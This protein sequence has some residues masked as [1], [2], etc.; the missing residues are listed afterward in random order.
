MLLTFDRRQAMRNKR[1]C[2][3]ALSGWAL[4]GYRYD[5][6]QAATTTAAQITS[7]RPAQ[8]LRG[9]PASVSRES[10]T[11]ESGYL[12]PQSITGSRPAIHRGESR[13]QMR[14]DGSAGRQR[15]SMVVGMTIDDPWWEPLLEYDGLLL[16]GKALAHMDPDKILIAV[17]SGRLRR[18]QRA[19]YLPSDRP[20]TPLVRARAAVLSSG[21]PRAVA[22]HGTAAKVHG[23]E[24][25]QPGSAEDVLVDNAVRRN[26]RKLLRFHRRALGPGEAEVIGGVPVT[27]I[28]RTLADL[29]ADEE[30]LLAVYALDSAIRGGLCTTDDVSVVLTNWRPAKSAIRVR[31]RLQESDGLAESPLETAG[32][33]ALRDAGLPLPTAQFQVWEQDGTL[34]ARL[35]AAYPEQKIGIEFDGASVHDQV[36]AL[37]RDRHRQNALGRLGWHVLRFT[38]WDVM[39][40]PAAFVDAIHRTLA[41]R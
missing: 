29:A 7:G 39:R 30:R 6:Q 11:T 2:W 32:R 27:T 16:R 12:S 23:I 34:V 35:D 21:V 36:P 37:F 1:G 28:P 20:D 18:V 24:L 19:V 15:W 10:S 4:K 22:S 13:P 26:D 31:L 3:L 25:V 40:N 33:L 14:S 41:D 38:W 17:R 8:P 9:N 5:G